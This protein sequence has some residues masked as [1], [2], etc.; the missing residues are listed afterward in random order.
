M[1]EVISVL[2]G[3]FGRGRARIYLGKENKPIDLGDPSQDE[4]NQ[5]YIAQIHRDISKNYV[6]ILINR[7]DPNAVSP[8]FLNPVDN[9][10]RTPSAEPSE[11]PGW[12]AHLI[13]ST[14]DQNGYHRA[15]L[16]QMPHVPSS[17][18]LTA[19]DQ[20]VERALENNPQYTYEFFTRT[21]GKLVTSHRPY[22]PRI[23]VS[24]VP[25][26]ALAKDLRQGTLS[27]ITLSKKAEQYQGPGE[28]DM[29]RKQRHQIV[30]AVT[31]EKD[32]NKVT[33]LVKGILSY[34]KEQDFDTISFK[35]ND[36]PGGR[37]SEPRV[38]VDEENA[39]DQLFVRSIRL[40]DFPQELAQCYAKLSP[41]IVSKMHILLESDEFWK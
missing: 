28:G 10:V 31:P 34:A 41:Q 37:S 24:K 11:S 21:S 5:I 33:A 26:E 39:L 35:V 12:S 22:R 8:A 17:S 4:K 1:D 9:S 29:I 15:C 14:K 7:G 16:E 32:K 18:I 6:A 13:I 20:I 27:R 30:L 3:E 25:S 36:L 23:E 2:E 38:P 40:T 19:F